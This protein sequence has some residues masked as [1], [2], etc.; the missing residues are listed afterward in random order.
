MQ[1]GLNNVIRMRSLA[2]SLHVCSYMPC[3][4]N[5]GMIL[6]SCTSHRRSMGA[7]Q[8]PHNLDASAKDHGTSNAKKRGSVRPNLTK[9]PADARLISSCLPCL[10][11]RPR[12][13]WMS[14]SFLK[15]YC[16]FLS[17]Q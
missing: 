15:L 7:S 8:F 4:D 2:L 9:F 1:T 3:H 11:E 10:S 13:P 17:L 12:F 14:L 16:P 5:R 6:R